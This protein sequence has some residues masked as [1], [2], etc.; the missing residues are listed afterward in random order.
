[1][2]KLKFPQVLN[3]DVAAA[4]TVT[5][6][7]A[8]L[9]PWHTSVLMVPEAKSEAVP[10]SPGGETIVPVMLDET[11]APDANFTTISALLRYE[12]PDDGGGGQVLQSS[13]VKKNGETTTYEVTTDLPAVPLSLSLHLEGGEV[14]WTSGSPATGGGY[15]L[16]DLAE[17]V[18]A[19]LERQAAEGE[20]E[21]PIELRFVVEASVGGKVTIELWELGYVRLKTW[22]WTNELDDTVRV[23]RNLTL[24]FAGAAAVPLE[25][26]NDPRL[27]LERITL[28]VGGT[29]EPE[30]MLGEVMAHDGRAFATIS[31]DYSL[32]QAFIPPSD[33]ALVGVSGFFYSPSQA[34]L[35]LEVQSDHGGV[36]ARDEPL[37][38]GKLA[39]APAE[40]GRGDWQL[41]R[42]DAPADLEEATRYWLVLKGIQG[43]V[44]MGLQAQSETN[45][46]ETQVNRAGTMWSPYGGDPLP[47]LRLVYLPG[48]DNQAAAVTVYLSG[49][50]VKQAL[51][52]AGQSARVTLPVPA[53]FT[54]AP[55]LLFTS[56][57]RGT[58]NIANVVQTYI[59]TD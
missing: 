49:T 34:E 15:Q 3:V 1:M 19:Y 56:H 22:S 28:D 2:L 52:P 42:L 32:G 18:N 36:P 20:I 33:I 59:P 53:S 26:L 41:V 17:A 4:R 54:G 58:L 48:V 51:D 25:S 11:I 39:L 6:M 24:D 14:L 16:P 10:V 5:P 50:E 43:R 45:L 57:A 40:D 31:S 30:R 46:R 27:R 23:D 12:A 55:T 7:Y 8:A 35:Y 37:A 29:F 13:A 47:L 21:T 44:L 9:T 38:S